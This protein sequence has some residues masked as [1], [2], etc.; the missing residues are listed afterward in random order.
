MPG[1]TAEIDSCRT[2]RAQK[3]GE[4]WREASEEDKEPY[5]ALVRPAALCSV[6]RA[7][8]S[9]HGRATARRRCAADG[10]PTAF[11]AVAGAPRPYGPV[12]SPLCPRPVSVPVPSRV[13]AHRRRLTRN[14]TSRRRREKPSRWPRVCRRA[15]SPS[16]RRRELLTRTTENYREENSRMFGALLGAPIGFSRPPDRRRLKNSLGVFAALRPTKLAANKVQNVIR[17]Q[18]QYHSPS[19]L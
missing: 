6:R 12:R 11:P 8:A 7:A 9:L 16:T 15:K 19:K 17:K 4:L 5:L 2:P 18:L 13:R 3:V 10:L 14:A 1:P